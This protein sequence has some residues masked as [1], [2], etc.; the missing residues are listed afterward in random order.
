MSPHQSGAAKPQGLRAVVC[1]MGPL[2]QLLPH[3]SLRRGTLRYLDQIV[4]PNPF[5][6]G[7]PDVLRRQGNVAARGLDRLVERKAQG[8]PGEH[9][10]G[11]RV[12]ARLGKR[13]LPQQQR[14]RLLQFV[15]G[16]WCGLHV[17]Q[18]ARHDAMRLGNIGGIATVLDLVNSPGSP[19]VEGR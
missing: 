17:L 9:P 8:S 10:P 16:G 13:N 7:R 5:G 2:A 12:D 19:D 4:G 14:F 3:G 15:R 11:D 6:K 1:C 18:I